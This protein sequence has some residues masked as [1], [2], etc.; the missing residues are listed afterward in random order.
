MRYSM[1]PNHRCSVP[2]NHVALD[3]ETTPVPK[4]DMP[5]VCQH[6]LMM[7]C[8]RAWRYEGGQKT[9][10]QAADVYSADA[11]WRWL[12]TRTHKRLPL[13]VWSHSLGFDLTALRFWHCLEDGMFRLRDE[14]PPAQAGAKRAAGKKPWQGMLVTDDP[15]TIIV[16]RTRDGCEVRF[17]DTLNWFF[18]PLAELGAELGLPKLEM[19]GEQGD[20]FDWLSYC[21]R[22]CEIVEATVDALR[23]FVLDNDLG[24]FQCTA[25]GQ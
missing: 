24:D 16:C 20:D 25:A 15:P 14:A 7:A 5:S 19:P 13:W 22:D 4:P 1:R 11:F 2:S 3:T 23:S 18:C 8:G 17:V 21:R 9:R 12:L 10:T 6:T